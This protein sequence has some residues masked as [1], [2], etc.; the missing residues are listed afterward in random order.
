MKNSKGD[1]FSWLVAIFLAVVVAATAWGFGGKAKWVP[2]FVSTAG[3]IAGV[4]LVIRVILDFRQRKRASVG[5]ILVIVVW[6]V[7]FYGSGEML[8]NSIFTEV[9]G[10]GFAIAEDSAGKPAHA[11]AGRA[12]KLIPMFRGELLLGLAAAFCL[13]SRNAIRFLLGLSGANV[14]ALAVIGGVFHFTTPGQ[15]LG[16]VK[17]ANRLHFGAF[18]YHNH[19]GGYALLGTGALFALAAYSWQK[20]GGIGGKG[21]PTL[22]YVVGAA[23]VSLMLPLGGG[24]TSTLLL[25]AVV[26]FAIVSITIIASKGRSLGKSAGIAFCSLAVLG[27]LILGVMYF[28]GKVVTNRAVDGGEKIAEI[29]EEG[30]E[31][32]SRI[33]IMQGAWDLYS[34]RPDYGWGI[35]GFSKMSPLFVPQDH[36]GRDQWAFY[37]HNDYLQILVETGWIGTTLLLLVPIG[38]GIFCAVRG[39]GNWISRFLAVGV[40]A[41]LLMAAYEFPFGNPAIVTLFVVLYG[42][43]GRYALLEGDVFRARE[44][45]SN[46]RKEKRRLKRG[47]SESKHLNGRSGGEATEGEF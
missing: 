3:Y 25:L 1:L 16:M 18:H 39:R 41:I 38:F 46:R 10:G 26:L 43:G 34:L 19:W 23:L 27:G 12:R 45:R 14:I 47:E 37:A 4:L 5:L 15:L 32:D 2:D 8:R 20:K 30:M 13:R 40:A 28:G 42:V 6:G 22:F 9:E 7:L 21:N 31:S 11:D 44:A 24:R 36:R 33:G 17:A 29:I 35:G